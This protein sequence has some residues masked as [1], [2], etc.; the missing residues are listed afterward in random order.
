MSKV[1]IK[2]NLEILGIHNENQLK[3]HD[4]FYW[5]QKKYREIAKQNLRDADE[6]LIEVNSAREYLES[7]DILKI[8]SFLKI[9]EKESLY[10]SKSRKIKNKKNT[11][12]K[13]IS[14][15]E[16]AILFEK[17]N[18][19]P[20][21]DFGGLLKQPLL[22]GIIFIVSFS[23]LMSIS[24]EYPNYNF[25][26]MFEISPFLAVFQFISAIITFISFNI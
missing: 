23:I 16:K 21:P 4:L 26:E 17:K 1:K 13:I 25:Y 9:K 7:I 11:V 14:S 22:V 3:N 19:K 12:K 24:A 6:K 15:R 5:W 20:S 2:R 8:F 10:P 18:Y